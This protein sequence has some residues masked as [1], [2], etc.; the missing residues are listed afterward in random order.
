MKRVS[1]ANAK[2]MAIGDAR[3]TD[4]MIRLDS[5]GVQMRVA[6]SL[7]RRGRGGALIDRQR[8]NAHLDRQGA[9]DFGIGS[10][11]DEDLAGRLRK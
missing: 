8:A 3:G 11:T 9:G 4:E 10:V 7:P 2:V 5:Q 6:K 1:S